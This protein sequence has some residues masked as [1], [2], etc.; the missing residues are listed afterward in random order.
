MALILEADVSERFSAVTTTF[1]A[2]TQLIVILMLITGFGADGFN[3]PDV[4]NALNAL[5]RL[6]VA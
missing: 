5:D 1:T 3:R 6:L 4:L 2:L